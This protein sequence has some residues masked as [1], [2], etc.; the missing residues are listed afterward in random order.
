MTENITTWHE[1]RKNHERSGEQNITCPEHLPTPGRSVRWPERVNIP[2]PHALIYKA[3][4]ASKQIS[5]ADVCTGGVT[6]DLNHT[7]RVWQVDTLLHF[8]ASLTYSRIV[9]CQF[10]VSCQQIP[11]KWLVAWSCEH[12]VE[13]QPQSGCSHIKSRN[14]CCSG[15]D[16]SA[17]TSPDCSSV[18]SFCITHW[19]SSRCVTSSPGWVTPH[20]DCNA[21]WSP[22]I[23]HWINPRGEM[24]VGWLEGYRWL[25]SNRR[26]FVWCVSL[27][28]RL[29]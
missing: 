24:R 21:N 17:D 14:I 7:D 6:T 16:V 4:L 3:T 20:F 15:T 10:V 12:N 2:C 11:L 25:S 9:G 1:I 28:I 23:G 29:F 13:V 22:S 18:F 19:P 26:E 5:S 27:H 8:C